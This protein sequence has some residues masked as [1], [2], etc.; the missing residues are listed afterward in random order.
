MLLALA[1]PPWLYFGCPDGLEQSL[2]AVI[3][4]EVGV[5]LEFLVEL[6]KV[7]DCLVD[8]VVKLIDTIFQGDP[9]R[10]PTGLDTAVGPRVF[11]SSAVVREWR[12]LVHGLAMTATA[13]IAASTS[14]CIMHSNW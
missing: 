14:L 10:G 6:E 9:F 12:W 4:D 5:L 13:S 3:P 2:P 7:M 1:L 11:T 8:G